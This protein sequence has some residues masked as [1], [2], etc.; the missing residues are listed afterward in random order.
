MKDRVC[1]SCY[2]VGKPIKQGAGSFFVDAMIWMT[3]I[4]LSILSAIFVLMI[5]PVAWTLY[6]L[7]VYDK[8]TCPKCERIAMV[9]LNSRKGREA[10]NG[11]K[12]VV[13]YKAPEAGKEEGEKQRR[14]DDHD[15]DSPKAV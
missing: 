15:G 11:P 10:L 14:G 6:H 13:S 9:S 4:S 12:W 8:T 5:I 7:W 2:H 1:T 3:F